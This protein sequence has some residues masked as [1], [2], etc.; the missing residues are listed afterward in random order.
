VTRIPR[1]LLLSAACWLSFG[2]PAVAARP[3]WHVGLQPALALD[4]PHG[5]LRPA[6]L[7]SA[8]LDFTF[9]RE[10]A[11]QVGWGP[12]VELGSWAFNDVRATALGQLIAP[13]D[14]LDL[15]VAA[16]PQWQFGSP[17]GAAIAGRAFFGY[18]A[19]NHTSPYGTG[20]GVFAGL[21]LPLH[22]APPTGLVG[23]H[24]DGMWASLPFLALASWIRGAP[25]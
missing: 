1:A 15:G 21:D 8:T 19:F 14:A 6:F 2:S 10:R 23:L 9:G 18:R 4:A 24:L 5:E 7:P 25:E 13:L 20:F 12:L 3:E 17:G 16:G 11:G 22:Q